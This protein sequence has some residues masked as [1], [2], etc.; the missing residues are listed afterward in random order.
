M[1]VSLGGAMNYETGKMKIAE[2]V[3]Y[4][5]DGRMNL[6]PP[7]QRGRVWSAKLRQKLLEN[8]LLSQNS[9]GFEE[10][11]RSMSSVEAK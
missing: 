4:F 7:F 6:I 11:C 9:D 3:G 10:V 1:I 8:R 2:L 5:A